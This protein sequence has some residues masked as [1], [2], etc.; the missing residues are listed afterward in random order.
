MD[1]YSVFFNRLTRCVNSTVL[2]NTT[3]TF[4]NSE[5]NVLCLNV[6]I[7]FRIIATNATDSTNYAAYDSKKKNNKRYYWEPHQVAILVT[8]YG[9]DK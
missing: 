1:I 2:T 3:L 7:Y 9:S 8:Q 5:K 6:Y 4:S